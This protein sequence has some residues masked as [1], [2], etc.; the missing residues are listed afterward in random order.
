MGGAL[1]LALAGRADPLLRVSIGIGVEHLGF[2]AV[3]LLGRLAESG[4]PRG[5]LEAAV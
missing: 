4:L 3:D 2:Q 1:A 5:G